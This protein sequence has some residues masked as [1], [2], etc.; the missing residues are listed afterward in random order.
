LQQYGFLPRLCMV[1]GA[2]AR[3]V[4]ILPFGGFRLCKL[5]RSL[6]AQKLHICMQ[7]HLHHAR[8]VQQKQIRMPQI[9]DMALQIAFGMRPEQLG[10]IAG[11][12][13]VPFDTIRLRMYQKQA[14]QH[15]GRRVESAVGFIEDILPAAAL[16]IKLRAFLHVRAARVGRLTG[17][18]RIAHGRRGGGAAGIQHIQKI[19]ELFIWNPVVPADR[20][21][22]HTAKEFGKRRPCVRL[23]K[24]QAP[25]GRI[26]ARPRGN[27]GEQILFG[28]AVEHWK[29]FHASTPSSK[30]NG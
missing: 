4:I 11:K 25:F 1:K 5:F 30:W 29:L 10:R 24:I 15:G 21:I 13:V 27:L 2:P 12:A 16:C 17:K 18:A 14:F 28:P 9:E 23:L 19:K 22:K 26:P 20:L 7:L 3:A 8:R 6:P